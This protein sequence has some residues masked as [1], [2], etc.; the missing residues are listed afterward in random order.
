MTWAHR[1]ARIQRALRVILVIAAYAAVAGCEPVRDDWS[2]VRRAPQPRAEV[3]MFRHTIQFPP[4]FGRMT[5]SEQ[6]RWETFL[7]HVKPEDAE[8]VSLSL[9]PAQSRTGPTEQALLRLRQQEIMAALRARGVP[10]EAM[11]ADADPA[12]IDGAVI[13]VRTHVVALPQCPDW[14][15]DPRRGYNNQPFSNWG[16]ATAINFGTMLADPRDLIRG[17][18]PG[19]ADGERLAKSIERYRLDKVRPLINDNA[20]GVSPQPTSS[21]SGDGG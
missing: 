20:T 10:V 2:G 17:K 18:E 8:T 14:S 5:R 1:N 19:P 13:A 15:A 21:H 11:Q 12:P 7:K 3:A 4:G 9:G 16:C 6:L